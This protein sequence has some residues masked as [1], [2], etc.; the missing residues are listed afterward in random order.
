[1]APTSPSESSAVTTTT[2]TATATKDG[3][4]PAAAAKKK[5]KKM[6]R[7]RKDRDDKPVEKAAGPVDVPRIVTSYL[8]TARAAGVLYLVLIA[9]R[10]ALAFAPGVIEKAESV[11]AAD[12]FAAKLL[13]GMHA[14][15]ALPTLPDGMRLGKVADG[16]AAKDVAKNYTRSVVGAFVSSG[17]PYAG[18]NIVCNQVPLVGKLL[19]APEAIGYVAV[20]AP[21]LWM[22]LLSL[23]GDV[24]LVDVLAV[25]NSEHAVPALLTYASSWMTLLAMSRNTN[26]ALEALCLLGLLAGCFG[27]TYKS[28]RPVFWFSATALALGIFLRPV[29]AV[30]ICTPLIYLVSLWG[31]PGV[32]SLQYARGA[33]EGAAIFGF[34]ASLWVAV[35]SVFY[36]TFSLRFGDTVMESLDMFVETALRG[37]AVSGRFNYKGS[38]VYTPLNACAGLFTRSFWTDIV[39]NTS[40]GQ[41]FIQLPVVLGPLM[42]MLLGESVEGMKLAIKELMGEFKSA[43]GQKAKKRKKKTGMS[44]EREEEMLV[45][46]DTIQTTLLLGLLLEVMQ[47][48]D[49]IGVLSLLALNAPAIICVAPTVFGALSSTNVRLAH[50]A[51]TGAMVLFYGLMH[52]SGVAR[53]LL[54]VGGGGVDA[55][56]HNSDLVIFRGHAHHPSS[57]LGAN[58]KGIRVHDG[59]EKRVDLM[60]KLRVL[61]EAPGYKEDQLLVCASGTV[62]MKEEEFALVDKVAFGHMSV[63]DLPDNLDAFFGATRLHLYKFIGDEDEAMMRDREEEEEQEEKDN[64]KKRSRKDR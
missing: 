51:Y 18:I 26:F 58:M 49:R 44:K 43:T 53:T 8:P 5:N 7:V 15:T 35:D 47:S 20:F 34:W 24:L 50:V 21:R 33:L 57:A 45:Y 6:V 1:M 40:P 13:P 16:V 11:D 19:C 10:L 55:I 46:L 25:Y 3:V 31:K 56:Q 28:P 4:V 12:Y 17:I 63:D 41:M 23:I 61:K 27:W 37:A 30:F 52:Q 54:A 60:T 39:R 48:H 36:G 9:L 59:G 29:F 14:A 64:E 38:L 42:I 32:N 62:P 22:F 2:A